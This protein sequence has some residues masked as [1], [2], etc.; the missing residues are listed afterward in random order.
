METLIEWDPAKADANRRKHGLS[1]ETASR[2]FADPLALTKFDRIEN[3]EQR[4]KTLGAVDGILLVVVAHTMSSTVGGAE[5][6]RV[7]SARRA[8]PKERK[9]YEQDCAF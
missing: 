6:I 5:V 1:F 4:W 7:I 9:R 3:G 8:E 2:V